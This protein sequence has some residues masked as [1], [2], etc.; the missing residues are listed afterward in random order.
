MGVFNWWKG[1]DEKESEQLDKAKWNPLE[2][3]SQLEEIIH[4]SGERTQIIFKNSTSCGISGM[5]KRSFEANYPLRPGQAELHLLHVQYNRELSHAI[6][7]EFE[8]RHESPQL[9]VIKNGNVVKH[10]S[11]G[12]INDVSLEDYL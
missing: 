7:R 4:R 2:T 11:H 1:T 8:V 5:V 12:S 9:L 3:E 10:A 6:A